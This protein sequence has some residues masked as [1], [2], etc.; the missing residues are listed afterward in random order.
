M[1]YAEGVLNV[2]SYIN[3]DYKCV[4]SRQELEPFYFLTKQYRSHTSAFFPSQISNPNST[5][6]SSDTSMHCH[7]K[8]VDLCQP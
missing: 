4:M 5:V 1:A 6:F 8:E 3:K 7:N 2:S